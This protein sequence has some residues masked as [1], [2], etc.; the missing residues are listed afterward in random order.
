MLVLEFSF[1]EKNQSKE[2]RMA[3][4]S[5]ILDQLL[6]HISRNEFQ[7]IVDR[8]QGDKGVRS[9][10]CWN[11]FVSLFF[12]QLTG[13][14]T[15]RD[16]VTAL[17]SGLH[18]LRHVGL[19][20]ACRSTLADANNSRPHEIYREL[21]DSL[22][23]RCAASAPGHGFRFAHKVYSLDA[24]VISLS[25]KVFKWADF[26]A[27]K[28]AI[29]LHM[30]LDLCGQIPSFCVITTGK[31]HEVNQAR[32]QQYEPDS[33][34]VFDRGYN[35]YHWF[36]Q[37]HLQGAHFVTR[38]KKDAS[39]R[40]VQRRP[41]DK[42]TGL[43]SDQTIRITGPRADCI[44]IPLRRIG[45]WDRETRRWYAFLTDIFHL[46]AEEVAALYKAR[47]KVELFFKWIKQ[48]LKIKSFLGTSP[49]A[50]M[51]QVWVALCV[52]LLT[53]YVKFLHRVRLSAY[54][55]FKR[56]QCTALEYLPLDQVL[57]SDWRGGRKA[58]QE[59]RQLKLW[60]P[61]AKPL[62]SGG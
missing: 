23:R 51:T 36:H 11:Q 5:S 15:L 32:L 14:H 50:V 42:K 43:T 21:F 26:R 8:H 41:V 56:L 24:T 35:D 58:K 39:Y 34:L 9:F 47:W 45:F 2:A 22:Y 19:G 46:T 18:K 48:H 37:L 10:R 55:L 31:E 30:M 53:S 61:R 52:Y 40:V 28:G 38:L 44:P 4:Y 49:N 12:G 60:P 59:W 29:K 7:Q 33:I 62:F 54:E 13:Q 57:R 27:R 1:C 6:Q 25:L 16:L 17:N 3:K 20:R